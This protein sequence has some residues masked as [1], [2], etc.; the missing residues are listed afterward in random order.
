MAKSRA[1]ILKND[2]TGGSLRGRVVKEGGGLAIYIDGF[3]NAEAG[4]EKSPV[5]WL[6]L[7][8][9]HLRMVTFPNYDSPEHMTVDLDGAKIP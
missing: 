1:F 5:A 6:V 8:D 9:G 4:G 7:Q 3:G 2:P